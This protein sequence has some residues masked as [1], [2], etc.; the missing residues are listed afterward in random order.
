MARGWFIT[1]EG[2]EGVGKSTQIS[3]LAARLSGSGRTVLTTRE[4]GGSPGAEAIREMLVNGAADRWSPQVE[5]LLM[6]AARRDHIER[7][8][9]PALARGDIVLC[10]RF[11]DSTRVYQ[12]AAGGV[13]SEVLSILEELVIEECRPGLTFV[14]DLPAEEGLARARSRQAGEGRFEAKGLA[15]HQKLREAFVGL[16]AQEPERCAVIDAKGAVEEVA[17]RIW[18]VLAKRAPELILGP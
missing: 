14:L 17:A 3:R 2:G 8:I 9:R 18:T 4:P 16:A 5:A 15:F 13:S 7:T 11:A 10:D 12:G 1:F 6:N